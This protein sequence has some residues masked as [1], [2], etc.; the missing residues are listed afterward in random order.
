MVEVNGNNDEF[1]AFLTER[2]GKT[3]TTAEMQ[4]EYR[5]VGFCAG[6]CVVERKSDNR[7]GSLDFT[8]SPRFYHSFKEG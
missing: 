4:E 6:L 8:H 2:V 7:C 5:V 3:L 1:R